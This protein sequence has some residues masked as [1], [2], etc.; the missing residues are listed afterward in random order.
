MARKKIVEIVLDIET[1]GLDY[2]R[3]RIIEFA[4]I[5]LEN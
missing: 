4:A 3:E 2:K 1:T 5:R